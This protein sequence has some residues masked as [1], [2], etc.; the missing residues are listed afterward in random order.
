MICEVQVNIL[1]AG[2]LDVLHVPL[3]KNWP[4]LDFPDAGMF[5]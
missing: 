2:H 5:A 4:I 1:L 3:T